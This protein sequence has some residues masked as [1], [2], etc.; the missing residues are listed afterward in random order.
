MDLTISRPI[1]IIALVAIIVAAGGGAMLTLS[2]KGSESTA[3][4]AVGQHSRTGTVASTTT[5]GHTAKPS[6]SKPASTRTAPPTSVAHTSPKPSTTSPVG[7]NGLPTI[8][9]AALR[10]HRIVVVSVFDPQS[11]TDGISYAEAKAGAKAAGVG[12]VGIDLLDSAVA[13]ALTT[14]LPGGG[15]LPEPGVLIYRGS[16]TLVELLDGFNDRDVVAQA[17]AAAVTAAPI[18]AETAA[19]AVAPS[20]PSAVPSDT[21]TTG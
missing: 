5:A 4:P 11:Q 13:G 14:S 12:F 18:T 7:A 9:D 3:P 19:T 17:A 1:R 8:L 15:L 6:G 21:T 10:K 2:R 20:A 16:G